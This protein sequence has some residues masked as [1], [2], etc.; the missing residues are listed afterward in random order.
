MLSL[1]PQTGRDRQL[2]LIIAAGGIATIPVCWASIPWAQRRRRRRW[3]GLPQEAK[4][5]ARD[6]IT[7]GP[8]ETGEVPRN[9]K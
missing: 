7:T 1:L 9:D 4:P 3:A 8:R 2:W 5:G 6:L